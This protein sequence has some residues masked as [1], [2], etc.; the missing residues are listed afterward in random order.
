MGDGDSGRGRSPAEVVGALLAAISDHRVGDVLALVDPQVVWV[1]AVRPG[2]SVY[3]GRAGV[4]QFMADLRAAFG[5]FRV[6]V[7]SITVEGGG[8]SQAG[9]QVTVRFGG[10]REVGAGQEP[11]PSLMAVFTVRSGLVTSMESQRE[12]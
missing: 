3:E 4:A 12:Y 2:L 11:M 8:D 9:T 10:V 6:V 1:P 5:R 7:R